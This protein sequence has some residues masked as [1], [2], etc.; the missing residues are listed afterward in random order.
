VPG[1]KSESQLPLNLRRILR[2]PGDMR[3]A[4]VPLRRGA[5]LLLG[6]VAIVLALG[7]HSRAFAGS[8]EVEAC[9]AGGN[10][11]HVAPQ[12]GEGFV[13]EN[14]CGSTGELKIRA[15][16]PKALGGIR[17]DLSAPSGTGIG[18]LELDRSFGGSWGT[19]FEWFIRG[20]G[21]SPF[22]ETVGGL[23]GEPPAGGHVEYNK[24]GSVQS[25]SAA[26]QCRIGMN[27]CQGNA[28]AT[29]AEITLKSIFATM[30]DNNPPQVSI[31]NPP[32]ATTPLRGTVQ[33][34]YKAEDRGSGV[35]ITDLAT[36]KV[37]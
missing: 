37:L 4:F 25:I 10:L 26:F 7:L 35:A 17:W 36:K 31:I 13:P 3:Q 2:V 1:R 16:G 6:A 19:N 29:L 27:G 5:A 14:G 23:T 32:S 18:K 20:E 22:L 15:T 8:Y 12:S 9:T 21:T 34:H 28:D 33:I 11:L 30:I 24:N